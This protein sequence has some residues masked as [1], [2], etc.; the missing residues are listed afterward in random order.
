MHSWL[1]DGI[2][3]SFWISGMFF[4]QGFMTGCLQTHARQY[5]IAIDR[6]S[7]SF[8]V[9]AEENIEEIEESPDDGVYVHGFYMD[10]AR[11]NREDGVID[12][13]APGELYDLMPVLHF[14]PVI[15][16]ERNV[17]EYACPCYKTG[18]RAGVLSTTGQSTNF[19][20]H[21]DIPSNVSPAVW[22]RRACA[23]LCQLND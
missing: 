1:V 10:G 11:Y 7:F 21:V 23:M 4:P 15:D 17:D 9:K 16:Y 22:T 3:K 12:E 6:L 14:K 13:Q 19:I 2:P 5:K 8:E 18:V 20:I